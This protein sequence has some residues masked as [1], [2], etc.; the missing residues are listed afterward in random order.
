MVHYVFMSVL[1]DINTC[2]FYI[3]LPCL[4]C[5]SNKEMNEIKIMT[6]KSFA[7]CNMFKSWRDSFKTRAINISANF[8]Y[9]IWLIK[10]NCFTQQYE[11]AI[12]NSWVNTDKHFLDPQWISKT[13]FA[14]E[15]FKIVYYSRYLIWRYIVSND[16]SF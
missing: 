12:N 2:T 6:R 5:W 11:Y 16:A 13:V 7:F 9:V 8:C 1:F 14:F 10:E 15:M 3:I 4:N